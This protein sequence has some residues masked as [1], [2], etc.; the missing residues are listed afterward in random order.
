MRTN[1]YGTI[2]AT[3]ALLPLMRRGGRV[4]NVCSRAGHLARMGEPARSR[5]AAARSKGEVTA[6]AEEFLQAR[7]GFI[8]HYS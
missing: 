8:F 1:L 2:A 4:V 5:L 3:E 7:A 6:L